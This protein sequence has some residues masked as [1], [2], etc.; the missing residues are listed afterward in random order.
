MSRWPSGSTPRP[1]RVAGQT[2]LKAAAMARQ[3][4]DRSLHPDR[5][6]YDRFTI[7]RLEELYVQ[8]GEFRWAWP[9]RLRESASHRVDRCRPL[10]G[11][12][13]FTSADYPW[14]IH[15]G[16]A[17]EPI[18]QIDLATVGAIGAV[19]LGSGLLQLW[20]G[21]TD[22]VLRVIPENAATHSELTAIPADLDALGYDER[23]NDPV[24]AN[25]V[26]VWRRSS[27]AIIGHRPRVLSGP[28]LLR[29][30]LE[31][32]L[33]R[34]L[35]PAL[36]RSLT[37]LDRLLP[38]TWSMPTPHYFGNFDLIQY[39]V[40]DRPPVVLALE[41]DG[42]FFWG[43]CGNAQ[44]FYKIAAVGAPEFSFDWSCQ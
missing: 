39:D 12:P 4:I 36:H 20:M 17:L 23:Y 6:F 15:G 30:A 3:M 11:G 1:T 41:S 16:R 29:T 13:L 25:T 19:D 27:F 7:A 37:R 24:R 26:P 44:L 38:D 43:D 8:C 5:C 32:C 10:L 40:I 31:G 14:P 28:P 22:G 42:I 9:L 2:I 35:R 18:A 34:N 33:V 21:D